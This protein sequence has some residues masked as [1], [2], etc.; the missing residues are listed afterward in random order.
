MG[1]PDHVTLTV[2]LQGPLSLQLK[3]TA[4]SYSG[5]K[6]KTKENMLTHTGDPNDDIEE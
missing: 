6:D 4:V 5:V 3:V 2:L 1:T